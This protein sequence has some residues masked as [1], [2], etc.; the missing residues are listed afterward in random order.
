MPELVR[1]TAVL[2]SAGLV[3]YSFAP[4]NCAERGSAVHRACELIDEDDLD[5]DSIPAISEAVGEDISGYL[6]AW[7]KF[8]RQSG[9]VVLSKEVTLENALY[10]VKGRLD[11]RGLFH[12]DPAILEIKTGK[13]M[14]WTGVQLA[15]YDWL[16][17]DPKPYLHHW[18]AE[19]HKDAT[20]QMIQYSDTYDTQAWL[21]CLSIHRWKEK[22]GL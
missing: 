10:G 12:N 17:P 2:R 20:Y 15:A 11:R 19:L 6:R 18:A 21:A 7:E 9:F 3:D 16:I 14:R 5:W 4:P 8:I 22:N 13:A 1:V